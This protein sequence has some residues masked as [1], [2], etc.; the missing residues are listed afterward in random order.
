M[1]KKSAI[2]AGAM[3]GGKR[4]KRFFGLISAVLR[5]ISPIFGD[6]SWPQNYFRGGPVA[7]FRKIATP[8]RAK[9]KGWFN[10]EGAAEGRRSSRSGGIC[11]LFQTQGRTSI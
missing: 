11:P 9:I 6:N 3:E 5:P 10:R 2:S 8:K 7:K 4:K 1:A